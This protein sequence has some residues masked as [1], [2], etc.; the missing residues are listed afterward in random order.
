MDNEIYDLCQKFPVVFDED[1]YDVLIREIEKEPH[2]EIIYGKN[3][4]VGVAELIGLEDYACTDLLLK[5]VDFDIEGYSVNL[6]II[7]N[8]YLDWETCETVNFVDNIEFG[9]WVEDD[10]LELKIWKFNDYNLGNLII[11]IS[12]NQNPDIM[13]YIKF[14]T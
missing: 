2:I 14:C 6:E 11:K 12:I 9:E 5:F 4:Y 10:T 8:E 3:T 7:K 13:A 1:Y